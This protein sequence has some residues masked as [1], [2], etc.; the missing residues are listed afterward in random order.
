MFRIDEIRAGELGVTLALSGALTA[1]YVAETKARIEQ[2]QQRSYAIKLDLAELRRVDRVG[3][4]FLLW[5]TRGSIPLLHLAPYV[6][7]W[8]K[9]EHLHNDVESIY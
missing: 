8:L 6:L 1:E 2:L 3:I 4:A 9:Q 5:A 7:T